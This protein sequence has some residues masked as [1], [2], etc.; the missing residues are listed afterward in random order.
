MCQLIIALTLVALGI[1]LIYLLNSWV[2][3]A[4]SVCS[5][6]SGHKH[7]LPDL[8][9]WRGLE[10]FKNLSTQNDYDENQTVDAMFSYLCVD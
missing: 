8:H 5:G 3:D 10:H 4:A 1:C 6:R 9:A 2:A 7:Q